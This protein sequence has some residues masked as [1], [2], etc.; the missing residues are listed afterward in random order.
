MR[1][2]KEST[3]A[4]VVRGTRL[5]LIAQL[6]AALLATL[7]TGFVLFQL[8]PLI[9]ERDAIRGAIATARVENEQLQRETSSLLEDLAAADDAAARMDSE[10]QELRDTLQDGRRT[11]Q[12]VSQAIKYYHSR[13]Y[14]QAI[15][16]YDKAL[17]LDSKNP[18]ILDLKSYSQFQA[19]DNDGAIASIQSALELAPTYLY[20]FSELS[21]YQCAAKDFD[22][23]VHTLEQALEAHGREAGTLY[24]NLIKTDGQFE[25]LC[26]PAKNRFLEAISKSEATE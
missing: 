24:T 7:A 26:S 25:R 12:F 2:S 9:G 8:G 14:E 15:A 3:I 6:F 1:L 22:G 21:R 16:W 20:G 19:E 5:L 18:W 10:I 17:T 13:K 4:A 11:T 23:S